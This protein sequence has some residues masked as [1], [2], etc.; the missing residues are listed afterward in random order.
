M[1]FGD[2]IEEIRYDHPVAYRTLCAIFVGAAIII[3]FLML[4]ATPMLRAMGITGLQVRA[5]ALSNALYWTV[6]ATL[7]N[8]PTPDEKPVIIYGNME[9]V[10]SDGRIIVTA[11]R[12]NQWVRLR[13]VVADTVIT[14][15]YG[16]AK[17]VG[18]LRLNDAKFE[19]YRGDQAVIWVNGVPLNVKFIESGVAKPDPS[20]PTDII[21]L[22]FATYYWGV[23]RGKSEGAKL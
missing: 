21:D 5:S 6:R 7:S 14:N 17:Q 8:R 22:A 9:G 18:D 3:M 11:P 23:V 13:L 1:Q 2:W 4:P 16:V 15:I 19:V 10:A 20:P 12:G